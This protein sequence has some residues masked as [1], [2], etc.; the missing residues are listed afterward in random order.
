MQGEAAYQI[1]I[2]CSKI[3]SII[4]TNSYNV[5]MQTKVANV[6]QIDSPPILALP[7]TWNGPLVE[8]DILNHKSCSS[9]TKPN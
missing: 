5:V 1:G 8:P 7:E 9:S 4:A 3:M 6:D 2:G